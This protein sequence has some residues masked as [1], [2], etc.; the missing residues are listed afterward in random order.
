MC[1]TAALFSFGLKPAL[2][3]SSCVYESEINFLPH[4]SLGKAEPY[5]YTENTCND[6]DS[7]WGLQGFL[8]GVALASSSHSSAER[9]KN[10]C[11][12]A[13]LCLCQVQLSL[14]FTNTH[15]HTGTQWAVVC[16]PF[17]SLASISS[18][19]HGPDFCGRNLDLDR[20]WVPS[21]VSMFRS[22]D[23]HTHCLMAF[24]TVWS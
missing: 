8:F 6:N 18:D 20:T 16:L 24:P 23:F 5:L 17:S 15:T 7:L 3:P 1:A 11:V 4:S 21:I 10:L 19:P 13:S 12:S 22:I 2:S 14:S 9:K